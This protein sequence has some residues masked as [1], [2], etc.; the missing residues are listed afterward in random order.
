ML[1]KLIAAA[2]VAVVFGLAVF[3]FLSVPETV[4]ASALSF[5]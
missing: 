2:V 4:S 1:R 3:W 5:S